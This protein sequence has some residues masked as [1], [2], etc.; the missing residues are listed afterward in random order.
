MHPPSTAG[1][2]QGKHVTSKPVS[3]LLLLTS[4]RRI[5]PRNIGKCGPC[6][7][8]ERPGTIILVRKDRA[9][10]VPA[11][12]LVTFCQAVNGKGHRVVG[13]HSSIDGQGAENALK[14]VKVAYSLESN[15]DNRGLIW[16]RLFLCMTTS[17]II[18][19]PARLQHCTLRIKNST[20][21]NKQVKFEIDIKYRNGSQT[22]PGH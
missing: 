15:L 14:A 9:R 19:R 10:T 22:H 7:S 17:P 1:E 18:T 5:Y 8:S 2:E 12:S 21:Y 11:L 4:R 6:V 13:M 3:L 16:S 20:F